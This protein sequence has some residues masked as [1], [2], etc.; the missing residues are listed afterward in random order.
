MKPVLTLFVLAAVAVASPSLAAPPKPAPKKVEPKK[1]ASQQAAPAPRAPA[2]PC[3]KPSVIVQQ[4]S[5]EDR[6]PMLKCDGTPAPLAV[7]HLSLLMRPSSSQKP[8]KT[9]A[10]LAAV[11]GEM[12]APGIRRVDARLIERLGKVAEHFQKVGQAVHIW[13]MSGYRPASTGSYHASARAI[14]FRIDGVKNE[15]LVAFCKTLNDTG[16]GY[17]PNS[18]FV[19]MDVRDPGAG[20]VSWIDASGPGEAPR[21]VTQWPPPPDDK[22]TPPAPGHSLTKL[23]KDL[24][25]LPPDEHPTHPDDVPAQPKEIAQQ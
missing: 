25:P 14:D 11:R 6:F 3:T 16:C 4:G 21:Y 20:H 8:N 19:H 9:I 13:V 17:Y 23:D 10:Q 24:P 2:K 15:A 12:L 1:H 5:E 7:E 22:K 18:L